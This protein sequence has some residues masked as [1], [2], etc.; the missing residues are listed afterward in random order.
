MTASGEAPPPN[1]DRV[2]E[3][4]PEPGWIEPVL[5]EELPGLAILTTTIKASPSRT[6]KEVREQLEILSSRMSGQQAI[7]LRQRPIPWAYRVFF[8]N[9][10]LDPDETRTP[11]EEVVLDRLQQGGYRSEN[12][13]QD[14]LRIAIA[15]T[16]VALRAFDADRLEGRLGLRQSQPDEPFAG[17]ASPLPDGTLVIADERRAVAYLFG[18]AA[19]GAEPGRRT[20][21][22]CLAAIQVA[23]VPDVA[24]EEAVWRA[25]SI[26]G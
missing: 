19:E 17:R 21:R 23:G 22:V 1:P 3:G 12:L 10:G 5:A 2:G 9:V 18:R 25:A 7:Q 24:V 14:A 13:V 8:R 20:T 11:I 16:G 26:M 6:P 15:E 4:P